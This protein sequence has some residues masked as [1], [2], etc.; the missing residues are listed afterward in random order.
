MDILVRRQEMQQDLE[1]LKTAVKEY[2]ERLRD[3]E[4]DL[5]LMIEQVRAGPK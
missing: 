2:E 5:K 3:R 1:G 4:I